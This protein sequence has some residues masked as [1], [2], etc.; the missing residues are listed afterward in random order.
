M[1]NTDHKIIRI[2]LKNYKIILTMWK[3]HLPKIG[4]FTVGLWAAYALYNSR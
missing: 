4:L 1:R 3:Q 2:E